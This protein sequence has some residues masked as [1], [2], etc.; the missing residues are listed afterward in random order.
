MPISFASTMFT[1]IAFAALQSACAS[2][3]TPADAGQRPCRGTSDCANLEVCA[4]HDSG[5]MATGVCE[6]E[7][8]C[9]RN[10]RRFWA[11]NGSTFLETCNGP[12][13][14]YVAAGECVPA[15]D[16][17]S[18]PD[19]GATP[20]AGA[21]TFPCGT[22]DCAVG[23]DYCTRRNGGIADN[24]HD[25]CQ[26]IPASCAGVPSCACV[27]A[28]LMCGGGSSCSCTESSGNVVVVVSLP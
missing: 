25:T 10:L 14:P 16:A 5:C 27:G 19:A 7:Y 11:C 21:R 28:A 3:V 15:V 17:G 13:R 22:T 4:F 24:E 26:P 6:Q 1:V 8:F 23:S 18:A 2:Y 9:G 20:D 12:D